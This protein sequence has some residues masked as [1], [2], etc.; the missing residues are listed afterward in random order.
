MNIEIGN[1]SDKRPFKRTR[2]VP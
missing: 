1:S 2:S